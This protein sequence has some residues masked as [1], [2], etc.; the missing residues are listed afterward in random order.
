MNQDFSRDVRPISEELVRE[1][2]RKVEEAARNCRRGDSHLQ[3]AVDH[4]DFRERLAE[5]FNDL[6]DEQRQILPIL[7]QIRNTPTRKIKLGTHESV[8][9]LCDALLSINIKITGSAN[10]LLRKINVAPELIE[11]ELLFLSQDDLGFPRGISMGHLN[12]MILRYGLEFCPAEVGL[13]LPLQYPNQPYKSVCVAMEPIKTHDGNDEAFYLVCDE[14][15]RWL[16]TYNAN[17]AVYWNSGSNWVIMS[18]S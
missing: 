11:R 12:Q 16:E 2:A 18:K 9:A 15:D 3:L 14:N 17:I 5:L 6:S 1:V 7:E 4:T 13:Q 10:E 8:N